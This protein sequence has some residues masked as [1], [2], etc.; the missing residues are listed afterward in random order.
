MTQSQR[1]LRDQ[2]ASPKQAQDCCDY[3]RKTI[4][5]LVGDHVARRTRIIYGGSVNPKNV[6][7]LWTQPDIDGFLV[8]GASLDPERFLAIIGCCSS[9]G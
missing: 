3:I 9:G 4:G 6:E 5:Q 2:P 7:S 8:G 1:F